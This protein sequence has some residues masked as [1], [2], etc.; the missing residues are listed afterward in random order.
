MTNFQG[1]PTMTQTKNKKLSFKEERRK[2][3]DSFIMK[4]I[5]IGDLYRETVKQDEKFI[6]SFIK[7]GK[8][9]D[10]RDLIRELTER[11]KD[12]TN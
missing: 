4:K 8:C 10:C 11:A 12:E 3:F 5:S 6:Q 1:G 9:N 7:K 2:A